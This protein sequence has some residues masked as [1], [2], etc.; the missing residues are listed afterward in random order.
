MNSWQDFISH[1]GKVSKEF[2]ADF[3]FLKIDLMSHWV[4]QIGQYRALEWYFAERHDQ[5]HNMDLKDVW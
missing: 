4:K 2:F 3:N 1:E 5:A